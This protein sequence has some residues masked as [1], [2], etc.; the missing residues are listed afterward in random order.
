MLLFELSFPILTNESRLYFNGYNVSY[1]NDCLNIKK[2]SLCSLFTY[3]NSFSAGK[4]KK[5]TTAEIIIF[6]IKL[7][8]SAEI[9]IKREDGT[10]LVSKSIENTCAEICS[11]SFSIADAKVGEVFY[12]EISAKTDCKIFS[13]CYETEVDFQREILLCASFCT[14]KREKYIIPNM[15]RI[16][17]F[18]KKYSIPLKV[19]VVDNGSTLP[20]TLSDDII[21]I[22]YNPNCGG[23]GGFARGLLEAVNASCTH[24][25]FLDDDITLDMNVVLKTYSLLKI[26]KPEYYESF[27]GG[28]MLNSEIPYLQHECGAL[29]D[30]FYLSPIGHN[31]DLREKTSISANEKLPN[32]AYQAWWY[33]CF[34][35]SFGEK[36]GYPMPY[37]IKSDDVEYGIRCHSPIITIN[38]IAVWHDGFEGKYAGHFEYYIKR[39]EL[40]NT[41]L[42]SKKTGIIINIRKLFA[43]ITRLT[44]LQ[45]YFL[46]ELIVKAYDDFLAGPNRF[47]ETD[48]AEFNLELAKLANPSTDKSIIKN[49]EIISSPKVTNPA[50]YYLTFGGHILPSKNIC[51]ELPLTDINVCKT[52]RARYIFHTKPDGSTAFVSKLKKRRLFWVIGQT[53]RM[54]FKFLTQYKKVREDYIQNKDKLISK[55]FWQNYFSK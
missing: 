25:I 13:G 54:F 43:S 16:R 11:L 33:C 30:G 3:F 39:N 31:V 23:S 22:V 50:L 2:D 45:R 42:Y 27:I 53:I 26:L 17:D 44:L 35:T 55:Q 36:F 46:A 40:V 49:A 28:A 29:W 18:S 9:Y 4:Y 34:P 6:K 12:P 51:I 37:F 41:A 5:Y 20:K 7:Q 15:E 8:G 21:S 1:A 24:V 48:L 10:I 19:F 32:A 14:Y 52:F 47:L 38:G